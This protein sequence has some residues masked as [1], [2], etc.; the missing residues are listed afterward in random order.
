MT[1]DKDPEQLT[2]AERLRRDGSPGARKVL[3][4]IVIAIIVASLLYTISGIMGF[5]GTIPFVPTENTGDS[6]MGTRRVPAPGPH[7]E[8]APAPTPA[9]KTAP[10]A[11]PV[12]TAPTPAAGAGTAAAK[13]PAETTP[14]APPV[15]AAK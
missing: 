11:A 3:G 13:P 6:Q 5:R 2:E 10:D 4:T 12:P 1:N 7:P 15:P 9:P 14:A 8:L